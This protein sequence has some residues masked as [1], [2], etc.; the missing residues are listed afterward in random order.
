MIFNKISKVW[1]SFD[2]LVHSIAF[3][4]KNELKGGYIDTSRKN[5]INTMNV[6]CYSFTA[7]CQ[8]ASKLMKKGGQILTLSYLG[9]ERLCLIITLWELQN[10]P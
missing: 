5:F 9:A 2:F 3:S 7:V 10:L 6:S 8:R 1:N 4:D